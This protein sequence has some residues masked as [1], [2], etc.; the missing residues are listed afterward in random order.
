MKS[1]LAISGLERPSRAAWRAMDAFYED[2]E[3]I[4]GHAASLEPD[5]VEVEL[6]G[7][8]MR[9]EPGQGVI[10]HGVDRDLTVEELSG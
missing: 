2:D 8:R 5:R 3:W 9:Q 7:K 6:D 1:R 4:V 10:S